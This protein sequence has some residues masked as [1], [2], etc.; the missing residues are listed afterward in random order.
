MNHLK[1][2][3]STPGRSRHTRES[4][5]DQ[6]DRVQRWFQHLTEFDEKHLVQ[7]NTDWT[8]AF[9]PEYAV[10]EVD[11]AYAFFMNCFHLKDWL[12]G[13][14]QV[15]KDGVEAHIRASQ[16]LSA[17]SDICHGVKHFELNRA[18]ADMH[19]RRARSYS[20]DGDV[21]LPFVLIGGQ[22]THLTSLAR[23]CIADWKTFL[24]QQAL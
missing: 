14:A 15:T 24:D 2:T 16:S 12:I 9:L 3:L 1:N 21:P 18:Q 19:W 13:S 22:Q 11:V 6:W 8:Y 7:D 5:R 4:W 17:C 10:E 23:Q 20:P